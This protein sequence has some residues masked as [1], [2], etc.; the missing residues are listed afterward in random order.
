MAG[1]VIVAMSGGVDSSVAALR[2]LRAGHEVQGLYMSN[3]EEDEEGYCASAE[4]FQDARR[5][6]EELGIP[7]H[8]VSFARQYRDQVFAHFLEEYA[9]GRTPNPDVLCNREIKFG[10][11]LEYARRLGAERFATGHYARVE[12]RL[13]G[14]RLLRAADRGKDQTYFLHAVGQEA[15]AMTL[16][17]IG[18][19]QKSEVREIA[20][21]AGLP[22]FAKRDSTGICF[23]G[24]R[25]FRRFLENYLPAQPGRIETDAGE[26]IGEHAGLMFYTLGQ[27]AGLGLGGR[28]GARDAPWYVAAKDLARNVLVVVQ[29]T[30]HP[31]LMSGGFTAGPLRWIAGAPPAGR[32]DCR[33]QVRYRQAAEPCSVVMTDPGAVEVVLGRAQRAVTPGQYAVFYDG[34]AC[35]GGGVIVAAE[36]AAHSAGARAAVV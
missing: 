23:I 29:E 33:V 6:C 13:D 15:L 14:V 20:R 7:L 19:L 30:H 25:P 3:W 5:V 2:L 27:R 31:L 8:R 16:F 18:D 4:D 17:P 34:E 11:C 35:L 32:F 22:V 21:A 24:E 1:R 10:A 9:A 12:Q 36:P 28:R 26:R